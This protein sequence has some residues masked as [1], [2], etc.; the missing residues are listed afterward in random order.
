MSMEGKTIIITGAGQGI[1]RRT[2]LTLA[3]RSA[4]VVIADV[5]DDRG[6][7]VQG[8]IAS[9][10]GRALYVHCNVASAADCARAV[11]EAATAFGRIDGLVNNASIFA[12]IKM[13][14]FWEIEEKDWDDLM[15]V[16]LKGVWLMS[17]AALPKLLEA[18]SASIVNISSST[19]LFGRPN[20]AHYVS[21]KAGVVGL[22]RAMA[23]ELGARNVRVN[24][25]LPGPIF[26]EVPRET[27][28]EEQKKGLIA[29]QCLN[30]PGAPD[31]I[32]NT[33]A[34]LLSDDSSFIT[35]QSLNVDGG[36][37]TH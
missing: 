27:V 30:R 31:D 10:G 19:M 20:Y 9:R 22:S 1:G 23:R 29:N 32:A 28:T 24:S 4:A 21:S 7:S 17:K 2:A 35:G 6:E 14:P 3:E 26:T 5:N 11:A 15:A 36:Y 25:V 37:M 18:P 13:K 12:T 16:N 34:F 8:E 33:V